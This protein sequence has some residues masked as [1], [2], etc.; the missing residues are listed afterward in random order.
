MGHMYIPNGEIGGY[1]WHLH[2]YHIGTSWKC[3]WLYRCL[4]RW[5]YFICAL[6]CIYWVSL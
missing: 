5:K 2:L 4:W 1:G 6:R 3:V